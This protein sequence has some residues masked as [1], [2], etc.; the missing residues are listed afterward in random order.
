[1]ISNHK[2]ETTSMQ[3]SLR[4]GA[5]TRSGDP[6]KS[7]AVAGKRRC[8]MH[9][10]A[11]GS[12][13]PIGNKNALKHGMYT[14]EAKHRNREIRDLLKESKELIEKIWAPIGAIRQTAQENRH[15]QPVRIAFISP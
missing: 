10:G 7:P 4:C 1:M 14:G 15:K 5:K 11:E 9:G 6:C 8:R 3:K 13:V 12:G 2:R